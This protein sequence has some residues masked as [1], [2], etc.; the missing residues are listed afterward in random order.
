MPKEAK[1]QTATGSTR[2]TQTSDR[3]KRRTRAT[4]KFGDTKEI[5]GTNEIAK[6]KEIEQLLKE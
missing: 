3:L 1:Q 6:L 5:L 2:V 4:V